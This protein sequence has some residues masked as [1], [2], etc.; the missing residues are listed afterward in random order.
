[1]RIM[2]MNGPNLNLLGR[3]EPHIYG[4]QTFESFFGELQRR[5]PQIEL[6]Y[7]QSNHEGDLLDELHRIGFEWEGIVINAG[8][9]THTSIA[10]ADA[11]A[12]ITT[13]VVEVHISAIHE[14]EAFRHH[15]FMKPYCVAQISGQGLEGY[16]Q[17]I[18]LLVDRQIQGA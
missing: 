15:S 4:R 9:Y 12:A 16:A 2:V 14:R 18:Q 17:A 8:A 1:M 10:L 7:F 5:F 6:V 3:R 13:P 11:I